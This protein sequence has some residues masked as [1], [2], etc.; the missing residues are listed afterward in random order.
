MVDE[1]GMYYRVPI[2][3]INDPENFNADFQTEKL[4][5]KVQPKEKAIATVKI[6]HAIMGDVV[7]K[8][9]S[10][11]LTILELKEDYIECNKNKDAKGLTTDR[12]RFFVMGKELKNDLFV[13]SY[14]ITPD[15]TIQAMIKAK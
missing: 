14:D 6:R 13:Y 9:V 2:C 3:V 5:G 12:V 4:K 8:R 11:L 10:N 7:L 15:L 1:T